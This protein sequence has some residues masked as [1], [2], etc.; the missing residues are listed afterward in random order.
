MFVL[1][2]PVLSVVSRVARNDEKTVIPPHTFFRHF[3]RSASC[4]FGGYRIQEVVERRIFCREDSRLQP[5]QRFPSDS[6]NHIMS[7]T[8]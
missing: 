8:L 3:M 6:S 4:T 7:T 1:L 2:V 5:K